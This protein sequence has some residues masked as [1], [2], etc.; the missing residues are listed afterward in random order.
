M[1][2]RLLQHLYWNTSR[3]QAC[4]GHTIN[5]HCGDTTSH[6]F[7]PCSFDISQIE[8]I[9]MLWVAKAVQTVSGSFHSGK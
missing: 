3:V 2:Y 9:K 6:L 4:E 7:A 5:V 1:P 8:Y